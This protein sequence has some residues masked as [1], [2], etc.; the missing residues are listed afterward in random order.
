LQSLNVKRKI[1][2]KDFRR[3]N[4]GVMVADIGFKRQLW[5]LDPE[6][7]V[8]WDNVGERWEIWKFPSQ[9]KKPLKRID[10]RAMHIASVVTKNRTFRELGADVLLKLQ[11]GDTKRFSIEQIASYLDK[12]D[13]N[14]QR[15]KRK[16]FQAEL[17]A[18]DE[19]VKE[20]WTK[21]KTAVPAKIKPSEEQLVLKVPTVK[22]NRYLIKVPRVQ[23]IAR[24]IGG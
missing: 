6:L 17:A 8:V 4:D 11:A 1:P 13:D 7:D 22:P 16:R 14:I 9:G 18:M 20:W 5:E 24:S 2:F 3:S 21:F 15:A 23:K 19:D 12:M 10:N